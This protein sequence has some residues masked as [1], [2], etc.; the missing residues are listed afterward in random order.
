MKNTDDCNIMARMDVLDKKLD[1]VLNYVNQQRLKSEA[2]EDLVSDLAII[3]KDFYDTSVVELENQSVEIDP[4]QLRRLAIN[5]A[6]HIGNFNDVIELFGSII[7]LLKEA[8][9]IANEIIIDFTKKL[10]EFEAKGYFEFF[11]ELVTVMDNIVTNFTREDIQMLADNIVLILQTVKSMTQPEMLKALNNA[12]RVYGS[13]ET[14]S[15]PQYS[16]WKALRELRTPEMKSALG[17]MITFM[18]NLSKTNN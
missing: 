4:D 17:F 8:G 14:A 10:H 2:V 6:K 15:I 13:V 11:A 3:G 5:L 16:F 1:L 12:V 7:D 9:P 18:K